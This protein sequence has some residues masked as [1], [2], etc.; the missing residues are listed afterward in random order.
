[1]AQWWE[2]SPPTDVAVILGFDAICGLSLLLVLFSAPS[3]FSQGTPGFP[4]PKN[5]HFQIL[6][7]SRFQWTNSQCGGATANS[8]YYYY[9]YHYYYLSFSTEL[10][11]IHLILC[12]WLQQLLHWQGN[13]CNWKMQVHLIQ[14]LTQIQQTHGKR[15]D[16]RKHNDI[17]RVHS[18]CVLQSVFQSVS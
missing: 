18:T 11:L 8:N 10:Y 17:H 6:I 4:S 12:Y 15:F 1:M 3:G 7:P 9:Y 5:Q 16:C 13:N 14:V 2:H